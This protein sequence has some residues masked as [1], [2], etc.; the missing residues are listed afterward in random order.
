M[1]TGKAFLMVVVI[2]ILA[3]IVIDTCTANIE[4]VK[5]VVQ[6]NNN[7][8]TGD[9]KNILTNFRGPLT[10]DSTIPFRY[11]PWGTYSGY[12]K[13]GKKYFQSY[14]SPGA[15]DCWLGS[16]SLW[17]NW[18]SAVLNDSNNPRT[19]TLNMPLELSEGYQLAIKSVDTKGNKL[20]LQLLKN[21]KVVNQATV[22]IVENPKICDNTY[23]YKTEINFLQDYYKSY[24]TI[25]AVHLKNA[26][27]GADGRI[28]VTVDGIWQISENAQQVCT[29]DICPV[30]ADCENGLCVCYF[31]GQVDCNGACVPM[32]DSNCGSCGNA[33][34]D[35]KQC[36][37]TH[38]VCIC[39]TGTTRYVGYPDKTPN[40]D[41]IQAAIDGSTDCDIIN[42][43][44][45][46]YE[47]NLVIDKDLVIIGAG[48]NT[49]IDGSGTD[50]TLIT[51]SNH[52]NNADQNHVIVTLDDMTIQNGNG[53]LGGGNGGGIGI[54]PYVDAT[55][56]D[57][58]I[59][60]NYGVWGG[61]INVNGN[62]ATLMVIGC[63]ISSNKAY[64]EGGG[65]LDRADVTV[66]GSTISNNVGSGG[67]IRDSGLLKVQNSI[68]SGNNAYGIDWE[69]NTVKPVIEDSQITGNSPSPYDIY[70]PI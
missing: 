7:N 13:D 63:T 67:G 52:N 8:N 28:Y 16:M 66:I 18:V 37:T 55:V 61:G 22:K 34:S 11:K 9:I 59:S 27:R 23:Y 60:D 39:P 36:D 5:Q 54:G 32:D 50:T 69:Q 56:K 41:S 53:K 29:T 24:D 12:I 46:T 40:Y 47:G 43:A 45:G 48:K 62:S 70:P 26:F 10:S 30:G 57:C 42:V 49:I 51:I 1:K 21:S 17:P 25:I 20:Y 31:T 19:I 65:I 68:I 58:I 64:Y 14:I 15:P 6:Q 44:E 35:G 3:I 4:P 38:G 2:F 33:C